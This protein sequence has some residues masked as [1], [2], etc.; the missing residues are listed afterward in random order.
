[1]IRL[2]LFC[3]A[4][5]CAHAAQL[6]AAASLRV[7]HDAALA[8]VDPQEK[9]RA[10]RQIAQT[11]PQTLG[12]L[13]LL[14]DIFMR[15]SSREARAAVLDSIARLGPESA[16]LEPG[17]LEFLK[18]P[19]AEAVLFGMK[20]LARLKSQRAVAELRKIAKG[21]FKAPRAAELAL[22]GERNEWWLIY[23][24]LSALADI[25]GPKAFA[26]I[27]S[28][29]RQTPSVAR[30]LT[31]CDW[32][33]T[34]PLVLSWSKNEKTLERAHEA[35]RA[36]PP[37]AQLRRARPAM[38]AA[39]RDSRTEREVRHQLAL[40]V[41]LSSEPSEVAQLLEEHAA[42]ADAETKLMLS[43]ALFASQ[44]PQI[45]PLLKDYARSHGAAS[46]RIGCLL[47]LKNMLSRDEF[48]PL[49]EDFS[50][51]DPDAE[52]RELAASLLK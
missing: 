34:L 6:P 28:K 46:T 23:E 9:S 39:L 32:E 4:A 18:L 14:F 20:G 21:R 36:T 29:V 52:N 12:D 40:K 16:H 2:L 49:A 45:I 30:L 26:L 8:A 1:M 5:L 50:K 48:R 11:S 17:F 22:P 24:A 27:K 47:Q 35:L 42:A 44:D 3:A 33:K 41:G 51:N 10:L 19:E 7:L 13:P 38:L 31:V 15:D 25:E 37:A 43:A